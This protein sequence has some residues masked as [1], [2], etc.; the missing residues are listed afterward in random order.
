MV[1]ESR[2]SL[3]RALEK[4]KRAD[5]RTVHACPLTSPPLSSL[6][7]REGARALVV[8]CGKCRDF[9]SIGATARTVDIERAMR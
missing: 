6:Q 4:F 9:Q 3:D 2:V 1:A 7:Q 5:N 8:K